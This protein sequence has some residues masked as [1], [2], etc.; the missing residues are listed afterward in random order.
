[1]VE[2]SGMKRSCTAFPYRA[3]T[4]WEQGFHCV[5]FPH[6]E[7][8]VF[9]TGFPVQLMKTGFSLWEILH[10]EN[11]VFI[12]G[13]GLQCGWKV[14]DWSLGLGCPS[15]MSNALRRPR[16]CWFQDVP[17]F[18]CPGT[19][20]FPCPTVPLSRDKKKI[21]TAL[22]ML[23]SC[24]RSIIFLPVFCTPICRTFNSLTLATVERSYFL[25]IV[26]N[27]RVPALRGF[28]NLEKPRFLKLL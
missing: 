7:K 6:R 18:L 11:P 8:P 4:G 14:Q 27:S 24:M 2:K 25:R 20:K 1:M 15:T 23:I 12:T 10:R 3:S 5:V 9:I 21:P 19:K 28:W 26:L 17:L 13:M 22:Q 16:K